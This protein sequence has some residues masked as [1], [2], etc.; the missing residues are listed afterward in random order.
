MFQD[1][2]S[3]K[4]GTN[5]LNNIEKVLNGEMKTLLLIEDPFGQSK[6]MD[7][8]AKSEPLTEEELKNLKTGYVVIDENNE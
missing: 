6:I 3:Q 8:H 7:I 2:S 4:N 5:L 1:E